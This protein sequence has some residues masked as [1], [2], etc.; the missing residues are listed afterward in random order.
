MT[1]NDLLLGWLIA[2][3]VYYD[4]YGIF[5]VYHIVAHLLTILSGNKW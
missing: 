4:Y 1:P 2:E 5:L 3:M